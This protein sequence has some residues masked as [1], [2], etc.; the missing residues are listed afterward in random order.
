[1]RDK[2]IEV[3]ATPFNKEIPEGEI[4]EK[5]LFYPPKDVKVPG[6]LYSFFAAETLTKQNYFACEKCKSSKAVKKLYIKDPPQIL[7]IV[8]KRFTNGLQ[9]NNSSV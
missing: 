1:M 3:P 8:I 5:G 7:T 9:K 2:H 6:L 4:K